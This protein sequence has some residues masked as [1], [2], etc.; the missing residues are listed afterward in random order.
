MVAII[1]LP[2]T[3]DNIPN[4]IL[5]IILRQAFDRYMERPAN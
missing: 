4:D 3:R 5:H 2:T 1:Y